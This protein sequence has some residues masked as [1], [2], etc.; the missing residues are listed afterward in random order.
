MQHDA[1]LAIVIS[2]ALVQAWPSVV[3]AAKKIFII[4]AI[5]TAGRLLIEHLGT[6]TH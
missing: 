2:G 5:F 6:A 4:I 1:A 3:G